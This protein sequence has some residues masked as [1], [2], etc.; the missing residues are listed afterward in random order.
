MLVF[1]VPGELQAAEGRIE[2]FWALDDVNELHDFLL[3][4]GINLS[5]DEPC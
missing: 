5:E 2:R 1:H 4:Q 3:T